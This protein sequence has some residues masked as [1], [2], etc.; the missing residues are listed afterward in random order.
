M[1]DK[2]PTCNAVV[3]VK[4]LKKIGGVKKNLSRAQEH[5]L[6]VCARQKGSGTAKGEREGQFRKHEAKLSRASFESDNGI[7]PRA[8]GIEGFPNDTGGSQQGTCYDLTHI[9]SVELEACV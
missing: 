8:A 6:H 5:A 7:R 1:S 2:S 9:D 3:A 4:R